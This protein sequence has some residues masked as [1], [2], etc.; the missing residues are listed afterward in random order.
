MVKSMAQKDKRITHLD[1]LLATS[2]RQVQHQAQEISGFK[3]LV[4][5]LRSQVGEMEAEN[6]KLKKDNISMEAKLEQEVKE[7]KTWKER[8]TKCEAKLEL[9]LNEKGELE[10]E[11]DK[12]KEEINEWSQQMEEIPDDH[13]GDDDDECETDLDGG[14]Q[15]T[16]EEEEVTGLDAFKEEVLTP[17]QNE[18]LMRDGMED[19]GAVSP[20]REMESQ[21]E[22]F[23]YGVMSS[24]PSSSL[25]LEPLPKK[26]VVNSHRVHAVATH[27]VG[28]GGF[29]CIC[30]KTFPTRMGLNCHVRHHMYKLRKKNPPEEDNPGEG[31]RQG[32]ELSKADQ[33]PSRK[34]PRTGQSKREP[35]SEW[36]WFNHKK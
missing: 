6:F 16:E 35:G 28:I 9:V 14:G 15:Q 25:V 18:N 2:Q 20:G 29:S 3:R 17:P 21:V 27:R 34:L 4:T 36:R 8:V 22:T 7:V 1:K 10:K 33:S 32:S 23:R 24:S 30:R 26:S 13:G 12:L 31:S 19:F 5:D 11:L